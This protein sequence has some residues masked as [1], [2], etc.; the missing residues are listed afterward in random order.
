[1]SSIG[2]LSTAFL[3]LLALTG[4]SS[5]PTRLERK[6]FDIT[7]NTFPQ[8]TLVTNIVSISPT[9]SLP[10]SPTGKLST[11]KPQLGSQTNVV[12]VTNLIEAY[13]YT[14][15]TNSA[16]LVATA[17]RAANLFGPWG[18]LVGVLLGGLIGG[19]GLLRSSRASKTAAALAQIIETGRQ[20]LQ[21]TP[22]GQVLDAKWKIWMMQHQA[23]Q[24]V[25]LDVIRL[26]HN[27]VDSQSAKQVAQSLITMMEHRQ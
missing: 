4:C 10:M 1:M 8:V 2:K 9:N 20:V 19:Y 15:N 27:A 17:A 24:G 25:M 7:T 21:S 6:F 14:P 22:Q 23:E 26:L 13:T 16:V 12:T 3:L 11:L 5:A 18:E